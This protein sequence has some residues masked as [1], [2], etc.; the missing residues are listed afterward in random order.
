MLAEVPLGVVTDTLPVL[1]ELTKAVILLDAF[2]L[3]ES[4]ALPPIFTEVVPVK[5]I[6]LINTLDVETPQEDVGEKEII[7]GLW[8]H[9]LIAAKL[10]KIPTTNFGFKFFITGNR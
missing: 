2:I 7:S 9:R 3:K 1:P 5:F 6:P 8:A 4:T 10:N